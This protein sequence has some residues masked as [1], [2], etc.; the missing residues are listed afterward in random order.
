MNKGFTLIELMIV[1]AIVGI[2]AGIGYPSYQSYVLKSQR[3]DVRIA[4]AKIQLLQE[5]YYLDHAE[6][7]NKFAASKTDTAE[8]VLQ[9]WFDETERYKFEF[10]A[11]SSAGTQAYSVVAKATNSQAYD[12]ECQT[13]SVNNFGELKAKNSKN[14]DSTA[15][16]W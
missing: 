15:A 4:L 11:A 16:C 6:Y 3:D 13:Y 14:V 9:G 7:A 10:G 1:V 12:S 8:G 5:E 2:L